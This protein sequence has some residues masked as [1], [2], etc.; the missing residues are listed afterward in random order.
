MPDDVNFASPSESCLPTANSSAV[1]APL[2]MP[3][4]PSGVGARNLCLVTPDIVGPVRN[5]GIGTACEA[6]ARTWS[7]AGH[8]V[9]VLFVSDQQ[10]DDH[11]AKA[12]VAR[13]AE[14][15]IK[16][17]FCPV[18]RQRLTNP[19]PLQLSYNAW[20][21][22]K[23][24][25]F[26]LIYFPE[27]KGLGHYTLAA[28]RSGMAFIRT[29]IIIGTHSP[30]LWHLEGNRQLPYIEAL[31]ADALERQSTEAADVV[32]SP[33]EYMLQW[34]Q[35]AG[36]ALPQKRLVI[37]NPLPAHAYGKPATTAN[38]Q[39]KEIVFFGR[40]ETRK[41]LYVFL[42]ALKNMEVKFFNG[43]S[44]TFLGKGDNTVVNAIHS[45]RIPGV[46][47]WNIL[48][49]KDTIEATDYVSS[50]GRLAVLPSLCENASMAVAECIGR[51]AAFLAF[52]VGGTSDL[53]HPDDWASHLLPPTPSA[54]TS[55]LRNALLH[56]LPPPAR[57][58]T[59][60]HAIEAMWR[61][62]VDTYTEPK[63]IEVPRCDWPLVSIVLVTRNRPD[64][65]L[66]ALDGIRAQTWPNLEVI[67]VDDGSTSPEALN[68]IESIREEFVD[69]DWK[70]INQENFYL[71]AARNAGWRC[72]SG[73]YI[74]FH[75]DDNISLPHLVETYVR[76]AQRAE[77]DIVTAAMAI[78]EGD[79][80]PDNG[81]EHAEE[82]FAPLG[83]VRSA[84]VFMNLYGDAHAC[85]RR[86]ALDRLG[87]FSEDYG[88]GHEDWELFAR[89]TINGM[90][91]I[92]VPEP[93]FWY[94]L[95]KNSMLRSSLS[96]EANL[97]RGGRPFIELLPPQYRA[98]L[99]HAL[100]LSCTT[101]SMKFCPLE[102]APEAVSYETFRH[103]LSPH[104]ASRC[105]RMS[106]A[107]Y[108][109]YGRPIIGPILTVIR[110]VF[111]G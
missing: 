15:G 98:A 24:R 37:P 20:M 111:T 103:P 34:L 43:I 85:I 91:V 106:L 69:R 66:Q 82:I 89:A 48:T 49:D 16:F 41:G 94:R 75:D 108:R 11:A 38:R 88:I 33:S 95:S 1:V 107:Y 3:P 18:S 44:V 4:S 61:S 110:R 51:G 9:T 60:P 30:T 45:A 25:Q 27:W 84:G 99:A 101:M 78:F 67:L 72:S 13:Y 87:G 52:D 74:I 50:P 100:A 39:V 80:L 54:L 22:L 86:V 105:G 59:L 76:C 31:C 32:V 14:I 56:G 93:L 12:W 10:I 5:G 81:I 73:E 46:N 28:K 40:L 36:W 6:I 64:T 58:T 7:D 92:S 109:L 63:R 83:G 79:D 68:I 57:P 2:V 77:A 65:L 21:W 23:T 29:Q 104:P 62:L 70:I 90:T 8:R 55:A 26:D 17:V 47:S 96:P 42:S 35:D 102:S 97:L 53:L 19:A 71:G